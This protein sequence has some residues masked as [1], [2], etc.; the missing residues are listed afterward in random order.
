ML[1]VICGQDFIQELCD[2]DIVAIEILSHCN[3]ILFTEELGNSDIVRGQ[4]LCD[5]IVEEFSD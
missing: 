4:E 1:V 3:A 2:R 5:H